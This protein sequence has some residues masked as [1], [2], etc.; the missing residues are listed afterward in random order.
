MG[1]EDKAQ[2]ESTETSS[3]ADDVTVG[4]NQSKEVSTTPSGP[5]ASDESENATLD[6]VTIKSTPPDNKSM[7]PATPEPAKVQNTGKISEGAA[8]DD[9]GVVTEPTAKDKYDALPKKDWFQVRLDARNTDAETLMSVYGKNGFDEFKDREEYWKDADIQKKFVDEFGLDARNMFDDFYDGMSVEYSNAK[10][11]RFTNTQSAMENYAESVFSFKN[12][13]NT[14]YLGSGKIQHGN[15]WSAGDRDQRQLYDRIHVKRKNKDGTEV[16]YYVDYSPEAL[17]KL[18]GDS[19]FD[20]LAYDEGAA[21]AINPYSEISGLAY[22]AIYKGVAYNDFLG[23]YSDVKNGQVVSRWD[24]ETGNVLDGVFNNNKLEADGVWDYAKLIVKSPVNFVDSILDITLQYGRMTLAAGYGM[25][26]II[27]GVN[28]VS[29]KNNELY[30]TLTS[31]GIRLKGRQMS[32]ST[33]AM[34]DGFFG[35]AEAFLSTVFDVGA[36]VLGARLLNTAGQSFVSSISKGMTAAEIKSSRELM[37]LV[38][39][40]GVLTGMAAKDSYNEALEIGFSEGEAAVIGGAMTFA[41]WKATKGAEYIYGKY[42]DKVVKKKVQESFS[43][44]IRRLWQENGI[45]KAVEEGVRDV[46]ENQVKKNFAKS[47]LTYARSAVQSAMNSKE[48]FLGGGAVNRALHE[49]RNEAF[50]ELTEEIYQDGVKHVVSLY[51]GVRYGGNVGD[52]RYLTIFDKGFIKDMAHR[53]ATSFV[54]G[55]IGGPMG[56]IGNGTVSKYSLTSTS[57]IAEIVASGNSKMLLDVAKLSLDS[58]RLGP[59]DLSTEYNEKVQAFEVMVKGKGDQVSLGKMLYD[60]ISHDINSTEMILHSGHFNDAMKRFSS[61]DDFKATVENVSMSSDFVRIAAETIDMHART[62]INLKIYD[63]LNEMTPTELQEELGA[64]SES[65]NKKIREKKKEKEDLKKEIDEWKVSQGEKKPNIDT[66]NDEEDLELQGK[67]K[68]LTR[69]DKEIE[70]LGEDLKEGDVSSLLENFRKIKAMSN[71]TASEWYLMQKWSHDDTVLGSIKNRKPGFERLGKTPILDKFNAVREGSMVREKDHLFKTKKSK[72]IEDKIDSYSTMDGDTSAE[73]SLLIARNGDLLSKQSIEKLVKLTEQIDYSVLN[74][75]LNPSSANYAFKDMSEGEKISLLIE[76]LRAEPVEGEILAQELENGGA[77]TLFTDFGK[78]KDLDELFA[79]MIAKGGFNKAKSISTRV[80]DAVMAVD[81]WKERGNITF[82]AQVKQAIAAGKLGASVL[83]TVLDDSLPGGMLNLMEKVATLNERKDTDAFDP[84]DFKAND[85]SIF[86]NMEQIGSKG[87]ATS[88]LSIADK[89]VDNVN[90]FLDSAIIIKDETGAEKTIFTMKDSTGVDEVLFQIEEREAFASFI[91]DF[92]PGKG[93]KFARALNGNKAAMLAKFRKNTIDILDNDYSP[94]RH[95]D[96]VTDEDHPFKDYTQFSDMFN[97]YFYDPIRLEKLED[98][99]NRSEEDNEFLKEVYNQKKLFSTGVLNDKGELTEFDEKVI[100]EVAAKLQLVFKN[101]STRD[102][103]VSGINALSGSVLVV[104]DGLTSISLNGITRLK[105]LKPILKSIKEN[106]KVSKDA[107]TPTA[108]IEEKQAHIKK[109]FSKMSNFI[110]DLGLPQDL[111]NKLEEE[112]PEYIHVIAGETTTDADYVKMAKTAMA[113]EQFL[114]KLYNGEYLDVLTSAG[115]TQASVNAIIE[116]KLGKDVEIDFE[117]LAA[118]TTDLTP[119]YS[120]LKTIITGLNPNSDDVFMAAQEHAAKAVAV[121]MY[122][123]AFNELSEKLIEKK[124]TNTFIGTFIEGSGGTGKSTITTEIGLKIGSLISDD[125]GNPSKVIPVGNHS[126]QVDIISKGVGANT[127]EVGGMMPTELQQLLEKALRG[128]QEAIDSLKEVGGI[129]IDEM[130]YI[131]FKA[132]DASTQ[133]VRISNLVKEYNSKHG[134]EDGRISLIGMGDSSQAGFAKVDAD[135]NVTGTSAFLDESTRRIS[136]DK[137]TYSFR[138]RNSYMTKSIAAIE[139]HAE[140]LT[141]IA[142]INEDGSLAG[143]KE[144]GSDEGILIHGKT[145][146]TWHGIKYETSSEKSSDK[147]KN[148]IDSKLVDIIASMDSA[149]ATNSKFTVLIAPESVEEFK[150]SGA[151]VLKYMADPTYAEFFT[152]LPADKVGGSEANYVFAEIPSN[153]YSAVQKTDRKIR[154]FVSKQIYTAASRP[155]D[156][157]HIVDKSDVGIIPFN[158]QGEQIDNEVLLP[159]TA[160]DVGAKTKVREMYLSILE[161]VEEGATLTKEEEEQREGLNKGVDIDEDTDE[162]TDEDADTD[163]DTDTNDPP[164]VDNEA[165]SEKFLL[166]IL[167]ISK[168]KDTTT[169]LQ[170]LLNEG[171]YDELDA[172]AEVLVNISGI[173]P[174]S[175]TEI[176]NK[177]IEGIKNK[178]FKDL[179]TSMVGTLVDDANVSDEAD[180]YA[181]V[182]MLAQNVTN[183]DVGASFSAGHVIVD[184]DPV[185]NQTIAAKI[186][187]VVDKIGNNADLVAIVEGFKTNEIKKP[188]K[189][190]ADTLEREGASPSIVKAIRDNLDNE[191]FMTAMFHIVGSIN[192]MYKAKTLVIGSLPF[193]EIQKNSAFA[194]INYSENDIGAVFGEYNDEESFKAAQEALELEKIEYEEAIKEEERI[195]LENE[196]DDKNEDDSKRADFDDSVREELFNKAMLLDINELDD[197]LGTE[198]SDSGIS[199]SDA[200]FDKGNYKKKSRKAEVRAAAKKARTKKIADRNKRRKEEDDRKNK[201]AA[202]A[203]AEEQRKLDKI[204][205]ERKAKEDKDRLQAI[206]DAEEGA[207]K[208]SLMQFKFLALDVTLSNLDRHISSKATTIPGGE[209]LGAYKA[210]LKAGYSK[211]AIKATMMEA[212]KYAR[213]TKREMG[214]LEKSIK[215]VKGLAELLG[216]SIEITGKSIEAITQDLITLENSNEEDIKWFVREAR[217]LLRTAYHADIDRTTSAGVKLFYDRGVDNYNLDDYAK[218]AD[219]K[220][221]TIHTINV[222]SA[223]KAGLE[224]K[225]GSD[226]RILNQEERM[227]LMGMGENGSGSQFAGYTKMSI[228]GVITDHSSIEMEVGSVAGKSRHEDFFIVIENRLGKKVAVAQ[229]DADTVEDPNSMRTSER[230]VHKYKNDTTTKI[231]NLLPAFDFRT[232]VRSVEFEGNISN[233]FTVRSGATTGSPSTLS[234][235]KDKNPGINVSKK[236]YVMIDTDSTM[237]GKSFIIFSPD[238]HVDLN[239]KEEALGNSLVAN[240][241]V[242]VKGEGAESNIGVIPLD[243]KIPFSKLVEVGPEKFSYRNTSSL[244]SMMMLKYI[245]TS[246]A[247][248]GFNANSGIEGNGKVVKVGKAA[249]SSAEGLLASYEA[250]SANISADNVKLIDDVI[251]NLTP[252]QISL[253]DDIAMLHMYNLAEHGIDSFKDHNNNE[254]KV[255]RWS[256]ENII[257]VENKKGVM[258][259]VLDINK[260]INMFG[261]AGF[262][263]SIPVMEGILSSLKFTITPVIADHSGKASAI[264]SIG[265]PGFLETFADHLMVP[266]S[267]VQPQ[268][269]ELSKD[270]T[271]EL[272]A[273]AEAAGHV[274][275]TVPQ[276]GKGTAHVPPPSS[277]AS[278]FKNLKDAV[279][280]AQ[281]SEDP[282]EI[283]AALSEMEKNMITL[284]GAGQMTEVEKL[285]KDIKRISSRLVMVEI[286]HNI[287]GIMS[288][289][290]DVSKLLNEVFSTSNRETL[291]LHHD[292]RE[293][294]EEDFFGVNEGKSTK[295]IIN[296]SIASFIQRFNTLNITSLQKRLILERLAKMSTDLLHSAIVDVDKIMPSDSFQLAMEKIVDGIDNVVIKDV[297]ISDFKNCV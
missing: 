252:E 69:L 3:K 121:S 237:A 215:G 119:F 206:K 19:D 281:T 234:E 232:G 103:I 251:A 204:E 165:E 138:G 174:G 224:K 72:E 80:D 123:N 136:V 263:N 33:E 113:L 266:A 83:Q 130:T 91:L 23:K 18:E 2:Q 54:A 65:V 141:R 20:G 106:I 154:N 40:R 110:E 243:I 135:G 34:Q 92:M 267:T 156:F 250:Q 74:D 47:A 173:G 122:S 134:V 248:R 291:E 242:K 284:T 101:Y 115:E 222:T 199:G 82:A 295:D 219:E 16:D 169:A 164:T 57:S 209:F 150:N 24:I 278:R 15:M 124:R 58:G 89:V 98:A 286:L 239:D 283:R 214:T 152:I 13:T 21:G 228:I 231:A 59:L 297:I 157:V 48:S 261:G 153:T 41:L 116:D 185:F 183:T 139:I 276:A 202:E 11:D 96:S 282:E 143:G 35:S 186:V 162:D 42:D 29:V 5:V 7:A 192:V 8:G 218:N 93:D 292:L 161:G 197:I 28:D 77:V 279:V 225:L 133:L 163:T 171:N 38:M 95:I 44:Y 27:P 262:K 112:A 188:F 160:L 191:S 60:Q 229:L 100:E 280:K 230:F 37:S 84:N 107:S 22:G 167:D 287:V 31:M 177:Q 221:G 220:R 146:G 85:L 51:G 241:F 155:F 178:F 78:G 172:I 213:D 66:G 181:I 140:S 274:W 4:A 94:K 147:L 238:S 245:G 212:L 68:G 210:L 32:M 1:T 235:F 223:A 288:S 290:K 128:E 43:V 148:S 253:L 111:K 25:Y 184:G 88:K 105:L 207:L 109:H 166:D 265:A 79:T 56:M 240:D 10:L 102:G 270:F 190:L 97:D 114:Y 182:S 126:S 256:Y 296:D 75:R 52:R 272:Q 67:K 55:G 198:H 61:D 49:A 205:E 145:D 259:N 63:E 81:T 170:L 244:A 99:S 277:I 275:T 62:K 159:D 76:L 187:D 129:L 108:F 6:G 180:I 45:E 87:L 12:E 264:S 193:N 39:V 247:R 196:K 36:Q 208:A 179:L 294:V 104:N 200:I 226:I 14:S 125:L 127:A 17:K 158:V 236:V 258:Y 194:G 249:I 149:L 211:D 142:N 189:T 255:N 50:E 168:S 195:R 289:N 26:N 9:K 144:A 151:Q 30:Q 203:R 71:G 131:E 257:K 268:E 246:I 137:M 175:D 120:Q 201:E 86:F 233:L 271:V 53:Y 132:S 269:I 285:E 216:I 46:A 64:I 90:R 227:E 118:V 254:H 273:K 217:K 176:I 117:L 73:L 260:L 70:L 293:I